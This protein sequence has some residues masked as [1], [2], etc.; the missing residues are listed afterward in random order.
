MQRDAVRTLR[1]QRDRDRNQLFH[2]PAQRAV[3]QT[4]HLAT[5]LKTKTLVSSCIQNIW[6][7]FIIAHR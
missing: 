3:S 6:V 1:R 7:E 2:F 4:Y 5:L